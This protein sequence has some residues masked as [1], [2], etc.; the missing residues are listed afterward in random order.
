MERRRFTAMLGAAA[1][2]AR[3]DAQPEVL[4]LSRNGWVP[5]NERLPVLLYRA[6]VPMVG[7][8]PAAGF[9][10]LFERHG[11]PPQWRDGIYDYHHYHST[12]HEVLGFAAG[13][14]RIVL[15]GEGGREIAV[16]PGDVAILP[17]GTGH[18]KVEA[19]RDLLVVGAYPP[20]Q[21]WDICRA[22]PTA[23]MLRRMERLAF[24]AADPVGGPGGTLPRLW[25][26]A[27]A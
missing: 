19:S 12:A 2:P 24:P 21:S 26:A 9:E 5:N 14:A 18:C 6:A 20:G 23:A 1:V 16:G 11:W 4:A 17:A 3:G 27:G 13:R 10:A 22:A 25:V 8:D 15:G 7:R